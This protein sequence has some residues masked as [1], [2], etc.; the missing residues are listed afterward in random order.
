ML[1]T[2]P[3]DLRIP[4]E[5]ARRFNSPTWQHPYMAGAVAYFAN[6]DITNVM[7][8]LSKSPRKLS[9]FGEQ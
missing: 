2:L 5:K 9:A 4:L 1:V 8:L 6:V 3:I 7:F